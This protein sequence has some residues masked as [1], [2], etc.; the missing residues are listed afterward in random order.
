MNKQQLQEALSFLFEANAIIGFELFLIIRNEGDLE[1]RLADL[2]D[3]DLPNEVKTG[4]MNYIYG[5]TFQNE[6]ALV[7]PISESNTSNDTIHY[8]NLTGVPEGLEVIDSPLQTNRISTFNFSTDSLNNVKGFLIKLSSVDRQVVLYKH[9]YQLNLLKQKNGVFFVKD[10]ERFAKPR[11]GILRFSFTID[12]LKVNNQLFV[13]DSKCLQREFKFN[14][15][16]INNAQ[17]RVIEIDAL[18]FIDN[19]SELESY[20]GDAKGAKK[21]LKLKRDSPVLSMP[22]LDI[23]NFVQ[24]H[25]YLKRRFKFNAA[26]TMFH[27][28][29]GASREYFIKLMNDNY[30]TSDLTNTY[31]DSHAKNH[32]AED[33]GEDD[34]DNREAAE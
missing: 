11:E 25:H 2:G 16:L 14:D 23:K 21:M 32:M 15:I 22:F 4:F 29:T 9:H 6:D 30:L 12:F 31:Y 10:N 28:H 27:L 34:S 24:N 8:Y 7:L 18:G 17:S 5:R 13:Y 33:V 1:L 20:A 26:G 19:I 3:G